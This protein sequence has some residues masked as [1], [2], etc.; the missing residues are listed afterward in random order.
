MCG[1]VGLLIKKP[2]LRESLG[3]FAVPMM[4]CMG[5]RGEDSAGLAV[6]RDPIDRA[7]RRF[8]LYSPKRDYDWTDLATMLKEQTKSPNKLEAVENHAAITTS[9]HPDSFSAFVVQ[10]DPALHVLS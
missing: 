5:D 4:D 7:V 3:K 1:I 8:S 10:Y 2:A 9:M 6:F